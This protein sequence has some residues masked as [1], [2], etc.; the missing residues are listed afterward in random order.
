MPSTRRFPATPRDQQANE[1]EHF[2]KVHCAPSVRHNHQGKPFCKDL[3]LTL[4]IGT[5]E[6]MYM[7]FQ[8]YRT[9]HRGADRRVFRT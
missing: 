4:L 3:K 7:E 6:A 8:G 9:A 1:G 2:G 5:K